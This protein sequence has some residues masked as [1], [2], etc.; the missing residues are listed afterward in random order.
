MKNLAIVIGIGL[1][2][3]SQALLAQLP[4]KAPPAAPPPAAAPT[5]PGTQTPAEEPQTNQ[6]GSFS[7]NQNILNVQSRPQWSNRYE[8]RRREES[9][10]PEYNLNENRTFRTIWK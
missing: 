7:N 3:L 4:T 8:P 6:G 5:Q 2:S 1:L 10:P 9:A